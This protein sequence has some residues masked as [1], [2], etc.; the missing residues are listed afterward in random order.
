MLRRFGLFC[1]TSALHSSMP[2][3]AQTGNVSSVI[4][5]F[6]GGLELVSEE[7]NHLGVIAGLFRQIGGHSSRFMLFCSF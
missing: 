3:S 6:D 7:L 2:A 1:R 5:V 4:D